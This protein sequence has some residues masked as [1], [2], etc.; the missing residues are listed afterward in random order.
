MS[1]L[2]ASRARVVVANPSDGGLLY[3]VGKLYLF[4]AGVLFGLGVLTLFFIYCWFSRNAPPVPDF[5]HYADVAPAVSRVYA[6]DGTKLGEFAK[7][8]REVVPFERIP[9]RL[10]NAFLAV[11]DHDFYHHG[12]LYWR[13]I[14]RAIWANLTAGGFAQG[15]STI[16][17]QVAKQFLGSEKSLSRKGKE[18]IMARRLELHYSKNAI[19]AVY[20]NHIY[21]GNGAFGV[22][23]AAQRYFGKRLDELTLAESALIAGL[24]QAPSSYDPTKYAKLAL[25]RRDIVLDKMAT[26]GFA[27]A[28]EVAAA[29][30][31]PLKLS[32]WKSVFPDRMPYYAEQVRRDLTERYGNSALFQSGLRIET[33]AEP[34]WEASAYEN[35]DFGARHQD[36]RQGWR[37]P[38]WRVDGAAKT[39]V[40][41][42]QKQL[43]GDGP[44]VIGKRYLAIVD[45]AD[46]EKAEVLVG[47][48]RLQ[49]PLRNMKWASKW[50]SGNADNDVEIDSPTQALKPGYV[51]WVS[52]ETRSLGRYRDW[53]MPDKTNPTWIP[54]DDQHEWDAAHPDVVKL[55][56]VPHPQAT[57]FT[58]DHHSGYV[59]AMVGGYDYDRS[60]FNRAVQACRQPGSTYKP[61]YYSLGLDQGYGFDTVL[62][63]I[64]VQITDPDTGE[65]WEPTNLGD[66]MDNAVTLEY[67]L[68]FSKN[69][70]SV[71]L[72]QRLGAK[73]VEAWVR[74]LGITT[75][76][77]ADDALALGASCS[78]MDE[79]ARAFTVFA[80]LGEWWPRPKG[81]E[82]DWI[83][84]RRIL[85]RAGNAVEDNTVPEDPQIAASD[86]FDRAA[87]LAGIAPTQAIASRTAYLMQRL[88]QHEVQFGFANVLRA[89]SLNAAGKTGTSSATGDNMFIAFTSKFTTLVWMGDDKKERALGKRDAA[90]MT[91]VPLWARYMYEAAKDYPNTEIPWYTPPGQKPDDR[92]DHTK[93]K[94]GPQMDLIFRP[95]PKKD[96]AST[97]P[98]P[99]V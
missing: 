82:K 80:R 52:R 3:W 64:P 76:I 72:F 37:G 16:T 85:D 69:I 99:P 21:L 95:P 56:Q 47:D 57:I 74:K 61:L 41:Q 38:E 12:G 83:Y 88:L 11:E 77:F 60:V 71:D 10:V 24:A 23:A 40:L 42:R 53:E 30:T 15:A 81:R 27:S 84:V 25:E 98:R 97:D 45:K 4:A 6:A 54:H 65:V 48:R 13:G 34:T 32:I 46:G 70:P 29:K 5:A 79:M 33:A 58:A 78:R 39:L 7:E 90:Y 43:Y 87:A 2:E 63:D 44:L 67:A 14:G 9:P 86:R 8:W 55:E 28:A 50:Q 22:A 92:G 31:E 93:G 20:L 36:K 68:V 75:K 18:A 73:N 26:F 17:Q 1:S 51:V 91:V 49:L 35:V 66:T 89:T 96:D 19:L 59:V 94:H 62:Q